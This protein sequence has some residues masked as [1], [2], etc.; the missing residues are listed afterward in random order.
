MFKAIKDKLLN[1]IVLYF[2][3][4]LKGKL[5]E[6]KLMD[7]KKWYLSK[8]VWSGIFAV[9]FGLYDAVSIHLAPQFGFTLPQ[10]PPIVYTI[11][12]ALGVY[13]RVTATSKVG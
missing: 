8:G 2:T 11:L 9:L 10:I 7:K 6:G 5:K 1:F 3:K 12:G 4:G 13:S